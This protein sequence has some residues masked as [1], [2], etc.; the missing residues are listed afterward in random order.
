[1]PRDDRVFTVLLACPADVQD[2]A[3]LVHEAVE[4]VN[5]GVGALQGVKLEVVHWQT[6]ASPGIGPDTQDVINR[7]L[8]DY[9]I[10]LG[11][12]WARFGTATP[13]AGS[14]TEEEFDRA[15]VRYKEDPH[16]VK[17]LFYFKQAPLPLDA[18]DVVQLQKVREFRDR[19]K[20]EG[21]LYREF[22]SSEEFSRQL[23]QHLGQQLVTPST[24]GD[25]ENAN[26]SQTLH[27][28]QDDEHGDDD[29]NDEN[30]DEL[31]FLD[32]VDTAE[33]QFSESLAV[34]KR[35]GTAI[36]EIGNKIRQRTEEIQDAVVGGKQLSRQEARALF[37]KAADDMN[38]FSDKLIKDLPSF[39]DTLSDGVV[40]TRAAAWLVPDGPNRDAQLKKVIDDLGGLRDGL[41][42]AIESLRDPLI[43]SRESIRRNRSVEQTSP[44]GW[45]LHNVARLG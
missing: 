23:R 32:Y 17:I 31:G 8:P 38:C 40:A 44:T 34:T 11:V 42:P 10:F 9:D 5:R 29:Q 25:G 14:G 20:Q 41:E 7:Q 6:H 26:D 15:L 33:E 12:M 3:G 27:Q 43:L 19:L 16:G 21:V 30:G 1:M 37:G 36:A 4:E 35:M 22:G 18:I 28:E 39:R 24:S 13:R 45:T 2:E